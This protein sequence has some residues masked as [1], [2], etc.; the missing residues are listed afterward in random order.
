MS[1]CYLLVADMLETI[2]WL[3]FSFDKWSDDKK[4]KQ[5]DNDKM[6]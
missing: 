2:M 3:S 4:K 1:T 6:K 5:N